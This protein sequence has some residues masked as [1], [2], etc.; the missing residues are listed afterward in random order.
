[1]PFFERFQE[2]VPAFFCL[3]DRRFIC[4]FLLLLICHQVQ[5]QSQPRYI[6]INTWTKWSAGKPSTFNR[7][8]ID[9]ILQKIDAPKNEKIHLGISYNFDLLRYNLDSLEHSLEKYLALSQQVRVPILINLDGV[10]Y[11]DGRPDLWNWWDPKK[12]GYNPDNKKNVEW[13][14]WDESYA[15][16]T[17]WRNWGAQFRVLP[18]PNLASPAVVKAHIVAFERLIPKI[19]RWYAQL[20]QDQKYLLGGVKVGWEASI[21]VNAYYY[22]DGNRYLEKMPNDRSLDPM[23]SFRAEGGVFGGLVPIGYAAVKTSGIRK[24]GQITREDIGLVVHKFLDTLS[25]TV[26]RLGLNKEQIYTHQGGTFAPWDKHLSFSAASNAYSRPGWSF[27]STD[28]ATAGDLIDVLDRRESSA[29]AAV[30]WWWPGTNKKEWMYNLERTLGFKNCRF[31]TIYNWDNSFERIPEG[32][33]AVREV[34]AQWQE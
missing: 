14:G 5:A 17:A 4:L 20:P 26:N 12:P 19:A 1:M 32:I 6:F 13:T 30:E 31:V 23:D 25:Y 2:K 15:I 10:N 7:K 28:P 22:K 34:I 9:Q 24:Q 29:W 33:A 3:V 16:K 27:Y 8:V 21:G 18:P 11:W